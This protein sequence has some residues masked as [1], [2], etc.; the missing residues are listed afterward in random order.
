MTDQS[1]SKESNRIIQDIELFRASAV[2]LQTKR[3]P[4]RS[5][6]RRDI[7]AWRQNVDKLLIEIRNLTPHVFGTDGDPIRKGKLE[8]EGWSGGDAAPEGK[9]QRAAQGT[10]A[11]MRAGSGGL[12]D[13]CR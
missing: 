12:P 4:D 6:V 11:T 9:T 10:A 2:T 5:I 1:Q 8:E 7:F 3:G 13:V